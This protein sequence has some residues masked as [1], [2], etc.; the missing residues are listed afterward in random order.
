MCHESRPQSTSFSQ[1]T[2]SYFSLKSRWSTRRPRV[3]LVCRGVV[4]KKRWHVPSATLVHSFM[5]L[6]N[7][8]QHFNRCTPIYAD[9]P[10]GELQL[11]LQTRWLIGT[12]GDLITDGWRHDYCCCLE[13][14]PYV[15]YHAP[16]FSVKA[17]WPQSRV[18]S[19]RILIWALTL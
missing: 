3:F 10:K 13:K 14:K 4:I 5:H 12:G 2:F 9:H 6:V 7:T 11:Q 17:V 16:T 1:F 15:E 18:L 19:I 8:C